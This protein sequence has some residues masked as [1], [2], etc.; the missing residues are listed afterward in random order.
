M[1]TVGSVALI[2]ITAGLTGYVLQRRKDKYTKVL[3]FLILAGLIVPPS[4]IPTYWVV[5]VLHLNG[6]LL[7]VILLEAVLGFSFAVILYQAFFNTI[8]KEI[9]E[10]ASVDGCSGLKLFFIIIQNRHKLRKP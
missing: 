4:M 7:A 8:P 2:V 1:I 5:K 6:T 10:A 3:S 9:D